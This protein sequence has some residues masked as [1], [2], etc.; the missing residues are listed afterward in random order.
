MNYEDIATIAIFTLSE[1][2]RLAGTSET[3]QDGEVLLSVINGSYSGNTIQIGTMQPFHIQKQV[4]KFL[5]DG[6]AFAN[7]SRTLYLVV[8]DMAMNAGTQ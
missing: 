3:L 7:V 1:Y 8:P 4:P 6:N 2:N 5:S